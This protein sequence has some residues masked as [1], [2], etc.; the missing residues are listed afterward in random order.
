MAVVA[1]GSIASCYWCNGSYDF[2]DSEAR[3]TE[4]EN[5]KRR[6]IMLYGQS[7]G[8][9]ILYVS[10]FI[11]IIGIFIADKI[12]IHKQDRFEGK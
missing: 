7:L 1:Y 9:I 12:I 3:Q 6:V 10:V 2:N 4:K 11:L 8:E 5:V